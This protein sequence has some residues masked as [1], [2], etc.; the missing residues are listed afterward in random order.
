M[1]LATSLGGGDQDC[2]DVSV[3]RISVLI[4]CHNA[5]AY[6]AET[7]ESV[8]AQSWPKLEVIVVDDGSTDGSAACTEAFAGRGVRLI[9]QDA[10]GA[11][12]ARNRAFSGATGDYIQFLDA[13]DLIDRD[14]LELQVKRLIARPGCVAS[15]EWGRFVKDP[16]ETIFA[17]EPTWEDLEPGAG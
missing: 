2:S 14:K 9:R 4:P 12:A 15:A 17:H 3:P 8:L 1:G 16:A 10:A 7:L 13:D 5:E 6:I 11:A